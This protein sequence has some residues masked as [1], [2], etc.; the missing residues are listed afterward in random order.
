[1][2]MGSFRRRTPEG[3]RQGGFT[4]IELSIVLV[5]IGLII[6]GVLKGQE[7]IRS[8]RLKMTISQ[9]DAIKAATNA[10]QDKYVALPGDYSQA[11][12][13]IVNAVT[14]G[15]GDGVVGAGGVITFAGTA[16]GTEERAFWNHLLRANL[17]SGPDQN[18]AGGWRMATKISNRHFSVLQGTYGG[19]AAHWLRLGAGA[20]TTVG[21]NGFTGMDAAELDRKFDDATPSTGTIQGH[22]STE[23]AVTCRATATAYAGTTVETCVLVLELL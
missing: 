23:G 1:M 15:D 5:L 8:T 7:L 13:Y 12:T 10:F 20:D 11:T 4:L 21:I 18:A 17:L 6:G 9:W 16:N 19:R 3:E 14:G 22:D 2:D